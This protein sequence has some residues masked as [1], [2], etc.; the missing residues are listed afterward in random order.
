MNEMSFALT[1]SKDMKNCYLATALTSIELYYLSSHN[2]KTIL[3]KNFGSKENK[4]LIEF[5]MRLLEK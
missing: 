4:K 2:V 5:E 1:L 3:V